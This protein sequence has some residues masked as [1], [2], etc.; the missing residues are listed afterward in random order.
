MGIQEHHGRRPVVEGVELV[1]VLDLA[2]VLPDEL[3][4]ALFPAAAG[5]PDRFG[6]KFAEMDIELPVDVL[7]GIIIQVGETARHVREHHVVPVAEHVPHEPGDE[8]SPGVVVSER[9]PRME[10][11]EQLHG[12]NAE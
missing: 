1:D 7:D 12:T 2:D 6:E 9:Q 5:K 8:P 11:Q 10:P 3:L 4:A